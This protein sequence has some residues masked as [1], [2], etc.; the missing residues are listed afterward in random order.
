MGIKDPKKKK[1]QHRLR[2]MRLMN[3][4]TLF[5]WESSEVIEGS[6]T[7]TALAKISH[8]TRQLNQKNVN[9]IATHRLNWVIVCRAICSVN[10]DAWIETEIRSV[11]DICVNEL[12]DEYDNMRE[13]VLASV[14]SK[15][16]VDLGWLAQSFDKN[17]PIDTNLELKH[18]GI[19]DSHRKAAWQQLHQEVLESSLRSLYI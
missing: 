18:L 6:R 7:C 5:S 4:I 8:V 9:L 11:K 3:N 12:A 1:N 16:V 10:N 15:Q 14:N 17:N 19:V 13:A 2:A